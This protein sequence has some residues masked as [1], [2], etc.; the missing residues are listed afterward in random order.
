MIDI[1]INADDFGFSENT[2]EATIKL[3][4]LKAI[5]SAT[6]M[7]SMPGTEFAIDYAKKIHNFPLDCI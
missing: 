4:E 2:V 7:L 5:S 1:I 3:F 6:I